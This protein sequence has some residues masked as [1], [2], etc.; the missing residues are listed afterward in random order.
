VP[1]LEPTEGRFSRYDTLLRIDDKL[2]DSVGAALLALLVNDDAAH[3][4]R[5]HHDREHQKGT[6]NHGYSFRSNPSVTKWYTIGT[7]PGL[8]VDRHLDPGNPF[9]LTGK[10]MPSKALLSRYGTIGTWGIC[11]LREAARHVGGI[12]ERT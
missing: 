4:N 10:G 1:H 11:R 12:R 5:D 2:L 7:S 3:K 6:V 8:A 9:Y